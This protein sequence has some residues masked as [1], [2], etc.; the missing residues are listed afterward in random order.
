MTPKKTERLSARKIEGFLADFANLMPPDAGIDAVLLR[1]KAA[2]CGIQ[3]QDRDASIRAH[4]AITKTDHFLKAYAGMFPPAF[5]AEFEEIQRAADDLVDGDVVN[6]GGRT[7][8]EIRD[9][10]RMAVWGLARQLQRI[11]TEPNLDDKN[12]YIDELRRWFY[13]RTEPKRSQ[14]IPAPPPSPSEFQTTL[15]YLKNNADRARRCENPQCPRPYHFTDHRNS[16]YCSEGCS[17]WAKR[18]AR[19]RWDR[20]ER[21]KKHG[22]RR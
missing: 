5:P 14:Q 15:L 1:I 12:W 3:A 10:T 8:A 19:R 17:D 2:A 21:G 22:K 4:A 6:A 9:A 7:G 16:R 18:E 11:W 20:K 13:Q